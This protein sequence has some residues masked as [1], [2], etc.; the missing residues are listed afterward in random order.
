MPGAGSRL[1]WSGPVSADVPVVADTELEAYY[2]YPEPVRRPYVRL[3]YISSINGKVAINGRSAALGS[4]G[5][6]LVFRR[7]RR[8]ADVVLVGAGT[9]RADGYRGAR[10]SKWLQD[11]RRARGQAGVPPIAVVTASADLDPEGP[12]FTDSWVPPLILTGGSAPRANLERLRESGAEIVMAGEEKPEIRQVIDSLAQR[13]LY[14]ILCEGGP[15]I[16]GQL[17]AADLVDEICLTLSPK[18]GG[19]GQVSIDSSKAQAMRL[20]SVLMR[21]EALLL[22]YVRQP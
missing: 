6:K 19:S 8:R 18:V 4:E 16:F 13:Q 10:S 9:V 2:S 17:F 14:R 1:L 3:N 21:D 22:R 20:E 15:T 11:A 7:L 12:L 5:D